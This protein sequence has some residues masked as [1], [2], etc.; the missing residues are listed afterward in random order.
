MHLKDPKDD[1][2]KELKTWTPNNLSEQKWLPVYSVR[3]SLQ[4]VHLALLE[5]THL[6]I[7]GSRSKAV[8]RSAQV[9]KALY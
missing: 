2:S 1:Y 8:I 9:S 5:A 6:W 4:G 7:F 3:I